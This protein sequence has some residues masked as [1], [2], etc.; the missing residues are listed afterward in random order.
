[1]KKLL[2]DERY[3][4]VSEKDKLFIIAFD[5]AITKAGYENSGI[6]PYVCLGKYKIEYSKIGLKN[7]KFVAR[8]YFRE[9]GIVL[10]LYF[11]NIDRHKN[12]IEM[13][14]MFIKN[15]FINDVGK[16]KQCDKNGGGITKNGKCSFKKSYTID[17]VSYEKCSG[18]NFYFNNHDIENIPKYIELLTTFYPNNKLS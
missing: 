7:K 6:Q 12:Y 3:S 4:F 9:H 11:N 1:M 13:S 5:E 18:E 8:F 15:P 10:R 17:N 14:D 16:C 2:S